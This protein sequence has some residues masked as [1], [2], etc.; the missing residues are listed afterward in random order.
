MNTTKVARSN[1]INCVICN[2]QSIQI[3]LDNIITR[4]YIHLNCIYNKYN[5]YNIIQ[6]DKYKIIY[7]TYTAILQ[8]TLYT[9]QNKNS[10][11]ILL[12]YCILYTYIYVCI[13]ILIYC[14]IILYNIYI[15]RN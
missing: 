8:N 4:Y 13:C 10:V 9:L 2:I 15:Q 5:T 12:I 14:I 11:N 1:S 3:Y 6:Y 7:K